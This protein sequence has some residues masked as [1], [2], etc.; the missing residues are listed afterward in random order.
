MKKPRANPY[1]PRPERRKRSRTPYE[2][3]AGACLIAHWKPRPIAALFDREAVLAAV[4]ESGGAIPT[5]A[6]VELM[7][8]E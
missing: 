1:R 8:V 5:R 7:R 6:L 4:R 2:V 3:G